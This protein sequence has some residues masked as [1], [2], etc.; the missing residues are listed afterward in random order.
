MS[1]KKKLIGVLSAVIV[2]AAAA[3][4]P[5]NATVGVPDTAAAVSAAGSYQAAVVKGDESELR[6]F[7]QNHPTSELTPQA[8]DQ[9]LILVGNGHG[10]DRR[11]DNGQHG[12]N[13]ANSH[14]RQSPN[15]ANPENANERALDAS[16]Y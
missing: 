14:D 1:E 8:L 13:N 3:G 7:L 2:G 4:P 16:I 5:A 15:H 6:A 9:L 12:I 11:G 10:N